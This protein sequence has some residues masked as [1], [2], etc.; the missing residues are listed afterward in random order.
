MIDV[1]PLRELHGNLSKDLIPPQLGGYWADIIDSGTR[2]CFAV[3][4]Y[5]G[6]SR[7]EQISFCVTKTTF[8]R[9]L[10]A[11]PFVGYGCCFDAVNIPLIREM[12]DKLEDVAKEND[13]L[14]MS[15][16]THPLSNLPS[17][18][19]KTIWP[20]HQYAYENFC[21][22]SELARGHPLNSL[23]H[24]DRMVFG[25][26]IARLSKSGFSIE[27][28][29]T[30]EDFFQ[31]YAVYVKRFAEFGVTPLPKEMFA[32]YLDESHGG[33]VDFWMAKS[34]QE[35][36]I[37]GI[38]FT[39]GQ[40]IVDYNISACD[41]EH[42]R[43]YAT[44]SILNAYLT[45]CIEDGVRYFNWQSSPGR[46]SGTY[47]YKARWGGDEYTHHYLSKALAP[48]EQITSIPLRVLKSE[49]PFCYVLPYSLWG[50]PRKV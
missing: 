13:C 49:L 47:R 33:N 27:S 39:K 35:G 4:G 19:H 11:M 40:G 44:T 7:K 50:E 1:M 15:L 37:G 22:V 2:T 5:E 23:S 10:F 14:A 36:V 31:W 38:I 24:R 18:F 45:K 8:G 41:S 46:N 43:F 3:L 34:R 32:R 29:P 42:R 9:F 6:G 28:S 48:L 30:Q 26:E 17:E 21:Q 12:M 16:C 20:G 25:A